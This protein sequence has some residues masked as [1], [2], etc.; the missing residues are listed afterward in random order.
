MKN[1]FKK[2]SIII[3]ALAIMIVIAGYLSFTNRDLAKDKEKVN[4]SIATSGT[5]VTDADTDG[6]GY[7][8]A[9]GTT[10]TNDTTTND[11]TTNDTT[12]GTTTNDTTT[13]DTTTTDTNTGNTNDTNTTTSTED[14]ATETNASNELGSNDISDEDMLADANEVADNGELNLE[15]GTPGDAV[16]ASASVDSGYFASVKLKREQVRAKNKAD[17]MGIIESSDASK[18]AVKEATDSMI[19][20]TEISEKENAAEMLLGA[21]GFEDSI[22]FIIDDKV[23]VV[24]DAASLSDQQLAI[25]ED[26]VKNETELS[27][28]NINIIPT[29]AED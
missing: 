26:I 3:T 10:T 14:K 20:L 11:T 9:T 19:A 21:K 5:D 24:V 1:I 29:V 2:N 13:N 16:L 27:V 23:D 12:N 15:D 17:L 25:I 28:K 22:V 7:D 8:L 4:D 18:D 6:D